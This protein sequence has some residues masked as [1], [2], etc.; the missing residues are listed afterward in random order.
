LFAAGKH[1]IVFQDTE[2]SPPVQ[3][4]GDQ[5]VDQVFSNK[6]IMIAKVKSCIFTKQ[7]YFNVFGTLV[8]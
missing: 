1:S 3:D 8:F 4:A 7:D 2:N 5:Q 6:L